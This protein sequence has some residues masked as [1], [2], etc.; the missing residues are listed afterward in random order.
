MRKQPQLSWLL[1]SLQLANRA[2]PKSV[3]HANS[4][5]KSC[6]NLHPLTTHHAKRRVEKKAVG[7]RRQLMLRSHHRSHDAK[8]WP[9]FRLG[10]SISCQARRRRL[11]EAHH[12]LV[13]SSTQLCASLWIPFRSKLQTQLQRRIRE[14]VKPSSNDRDRRDVL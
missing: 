3:L 8:Q 1:Q 11:F 5:N 14:G 7:M 10:T 6:W 9:T 12:P 2:L 4:T 13:E